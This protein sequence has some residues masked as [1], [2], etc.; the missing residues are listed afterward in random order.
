MAGIIGR[1]SSGVCT[2]QNWIRPRNAVSCEAR[3]HLVQTTVLGCVV[4]EKGTVQ[5]W[6]RGEL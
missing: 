3:G 1:H 4:V 5:S 2:E 6:M